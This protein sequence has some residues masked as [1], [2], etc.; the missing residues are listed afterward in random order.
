MENNPLMLNKQDLVLIFLVIASFKA[1]ERKVQGFKQ[2]KIKGN[3]IL[4][5]LKVTR[6]LKSII[7]R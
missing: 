3:D 1:P 2:I 7:G 4:W 5:P 6:R